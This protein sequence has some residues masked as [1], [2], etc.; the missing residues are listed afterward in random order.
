MSEASELRRRLKRLGRSRQPDRVPQSPAPT[1]GE[2]GMPPGEEVATP[3]G[4]AFRIERLYPGDH[5]HG[6]GPLSQ[7]LELSPRLAAAVAN[8]P[9]L[10]GIPLDGLAFLD[11]E[12]TGLA[13]GA[14]TLVFLVGVGCFTPAGFRLRQYF[15]RDPGEEPAF[16]QALEEDLVQAGGFVTF[17]GQAFD[18]PLLEIRYRIGLGRDRPLTT[19]PHLDLLM[20]SRRLWRAVLPDCTLSTIERA[21]LRVERERKDVPG[22]RIPALYQEY[23]RTGD[24]G[25]MGRVVYHN[26]IDVLSLVTLSTQVLARHREEALGEL[27]SAE[28]LAVARWHHAAGRLDPAEA[29]YRAALEAESEDRIRLETLRRYTFHLK[30]TERWE[31]ALEG[32]MAWHALDPGDPAPC[33]ELAKY[34]E[35][36]TGEMEQAL[37]WAEAALVSLSHWESDWRRDEVWGAVEHRLRRLVHKLQ[38]R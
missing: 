16:L 25:E 35:W 18:L 2:T 34:Y 1:W 4:P 6:P 29:A 37:V 19:W 22:A 11:T 26:A 10:E 14:G 27:E 9:A 5:V 31:D 17:N 38:Q 28:A 32:W 8:R 30:R 12:T 7:V 33:L 24:P 36:C 3:S 15:L 20:P 13:G 23:L 21:V